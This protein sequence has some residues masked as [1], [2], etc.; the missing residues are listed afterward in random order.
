ML[1]GYLVELWRDANQY[2]PNLN[3]MNWSGSDQVWEYQR[4]MQA[5]GDN[6]MDLSP[7]TY[8]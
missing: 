2:A 6:V 1:I 5:S 8:S 3:C 7:M 4:F